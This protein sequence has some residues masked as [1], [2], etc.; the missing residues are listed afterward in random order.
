MNTQICVE[1]PEGF[2]FAELADSLRAK[3]VMRYG[4]ISIDRQ[5][6]IHKAAS[7]MVQMNVSCLPVT[8]EGLITGMLS[9]KDLL[10]SYHKQGYLPGLAEDYMTE[11]YI[12]YD[13]EDY[14]SNICQCL[15]ENPFRHVPI[16]MQGMLAGMITR[17]DLICKFLKH[18][19]TVNPSDNYHKQGDCLMAEDAMKCGLASLL[20]DAT[21]ADAMDMIVKHHVMGISIVNPAAELLGI[22]TEK[23]IL[24]NISHVD[25]IATKVE[26]YMTR[27]V[28]AFGPK[29]DLGEVCGCLLKHDFHQVPVVN[30]SRLVGMITR[31]DV[32]KARMRSF[33]L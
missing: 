27:D 3:E 4:V 33:K 23:D 14:L 9:D 6:P 2:T 12:S 16:L 21:F 8:R 20:P 22:I 13:V 31:S 18:A 1:Y 24:S 30:N 11:S 5:E 17:S 28:I 29:S 7:L 25:V 32:L 26:D 19:R 15:N 10:R